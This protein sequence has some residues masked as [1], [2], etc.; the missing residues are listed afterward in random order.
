MK[1]SKK[2]LFFIPVTAGVLLIISMV[3]T[4][5]GPVRPEISEQ[6]RTVSVVIIKPMSIIP[7]ITGYGYVQPTETWEALPEVSGKIIEIHPELKRGAFISK[8]SLLVRIDPQSYGFAESRGVA[9]VITAEAQLKE[10][11]QQKSNTEKLLRIERQKLQLTR[12]EL[13]RKKKL[14]AKGYISASELE[15]EERNLLAQQTGVDNLVNTLELIPSQEKAL[16]AQK[17]SDVSSLSERRLD[18]EKTVIRAPFDCRISEVNIELNQFAPAG[19]RILKAVNISRVEIPVQLSPSEFSN[20][21]APMLGDRS[22]IETTN[23][24]MDAIRKLIGISATIRIPLF[25]KN[26]EWEGIFMR[27]SES[28]DLD[29]GAI[30]VFVAV[31]QP[32]QKIIPSERP[33]LVPNLYTEVE[34]QGSPRT[35][36]YIIPFQAI[37]NGY[38]YVVSK[39]SRLQRQKVDIEMVMNDLAIIHEGIEENVS[40][41]TTDLVP[42]IE[43]MLLTPVVNEELTAMIDALDIQN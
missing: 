36:R 38:I 8:G 17:E 5:K 43:G 34:L 11:A 7:R 1:I 35:Q 14:F 37:H 39:E 6:S 40:V 10:L 19:S 21:L 24:D 4:K 3:T 31:D 23:L 16:L 22:P 27:T 15:Q 33:P 9:S 18:I 29:T 26:A 12:Q 25:H 28:I 13:D 30:T 2:L 32:Y 20:L 41:I 42:A